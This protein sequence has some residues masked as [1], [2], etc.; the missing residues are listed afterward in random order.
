MNHLNKTILS[1]AVALT[2]SHVQ[3]AG[4]QL[5]GQSATGLGRAFAGD[6]VIADNASAMSRNVAAMSL[7]TETQL[8]LGIIV[9]DTDVSLKDAQFTYLTPKGYNTVAIA[10]VNDISGTN[11]APN[12]F[13]VHPIDQQLTVGFGLYSNFATTT[14]YDDAFI[15]D[16]FGGTTKVRSV[17]LEANVS[18]R[19]SEQW[20]IGG[21]LDVIYGAG[22]LYREFK[23]AGLDSSKPA[24]DVE[25]DGFTLGWHVGAMYELNADHRFGLSYRYS[26]SLKVKGDF[27]LQGQ[28]FDD[29]TL[30]L[31][32]PS[33]AEF[34]GFHQLTN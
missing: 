5:N 1:L 3:A 11:I 28:S 19:F 2:C 8:S 10:D 9:I 26:P 29:D 21:G 16:L 4:F 7:F 18:Y 34:S 24:L 22:E 14:Q 13:I 27:V 15:A 23:G 6:G 31:P 30:T 17:N 20:S 33:M 32:L 25:G 12:I